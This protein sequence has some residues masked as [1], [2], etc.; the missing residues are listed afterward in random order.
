MPKDPKRTTDISRNSRTISRTSSTKWCTSS[1]CVATAGDFI[2]EEM[3]KAEYS[4]VLYADWR[5]ANLSNKII[6]LVTYFV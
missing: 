4:S 3:A 2:R 5:G 1:Q 6:S